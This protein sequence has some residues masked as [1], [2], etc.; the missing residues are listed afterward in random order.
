MMARAFLMSGRED[1]NPSRDN[2]E[3]VVFVLV[4]YHRYCQGIS[5]INQSFFISF[6]SML[7]ISFSLVCRPAANAILPT[8]PSSYSFVS[9]LPFSTQPLLIHTAHSHSK[10][11]EKWGHV[12]ALLIQPFKELTIYG[13]SEL[14]K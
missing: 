14:T 1:Q 5:L 11:K 2:F 10:K 6:S 3:M 12:T 13:T 8:F 7:C 4:Y 9:S